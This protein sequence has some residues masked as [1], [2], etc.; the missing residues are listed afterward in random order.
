MAGRCLILSLT[1]AAWLLGA[2]SVLGATRYDPRLRFRTVSTPR[3]DIHFHQ[4]GERMAGRLA[5]FIEAAAAEVDASIGPAVGRV[6]VILVDQHDLSNGWATPLPYNT[7]EISAAAPPAESVIGNTDDWLRLVFIHEYTHIAHLSRAGGWIGALRR[8]FGRMPVL[9]P[10]LYQPIWG[11]EGLATWQ[12]S[13]STAQGRVNAGDFRLLLKRAAGTGRF[14]PLDRAN[15]GN[16]DWPGGTTPYLYGAYFHAFLAER[17]GAESLR[18]LADETARRL[19]YFAP[20]AYRKVYGQSVGS[21]WRE[22]QEATRED[23]EAD[24]DAERLTFHGFNVTGPRVGADGRIFYSVSNPHTFPALMELRHPGGTPREVT[25]RYQGRAIALAGRH[26]VVDEID[27]VRSVGLQSDLYLIDPEDGERRRLTREARAL[28]P[29]VAPGG[30]TVA[31]VV[32]LHDRR[33]I[34]T[35]ALPAAGE[36]TPDILIGEE[37][38]DYSLPRWSPDGRWIAAERRRL[39][40]PSEIVV[41]DP[42]GRTVRVLASLPGG[43]SASPVWTPDGTHVLF[44]A[45][46]N[47][48]PFQ[49][50]RAHVATGVIERLEGTGRSARSPDVSPD[51]S[52]LVYVGYTAEGYDL[53]SLSMADARWTGVGAAGRSESPGSTFTGGVAADRAEPR[54]YSA[55]KTLAP[56]FWTPTVESDGDELVI[57]GA[58]GSADALGRHAYGVEGGWS[59][60][61]RPDWRVAYAYDRWRP[62]VFAALSDDTDPWRDGVVRTREADLGMLLRVSRVRFTHATFA[63]L[64][65]AADEFAC[66]GCAPPVDAQLRRSALRLGWNFSNAR[67]FGYSIS[68]EEGGRVS[69]TLELPRTALGSDGNGAAATLDGRRYWRLWPRHGVLA[70]RGA[71]AAS[72]GDENSLREFRASG[73]GPQTAGFGFGRGAVGL[74]RGFSEEAVTGTRAAVVNLDYRVPL[75]RVDRGFGTIPIF[76]RSLHGAVFLDAGH[77]WTDVARWQDRKLSVGAEISTDT[78]V[79]FALPVTFTAGAAWRHGAAGDERS[80]AAFVRVGRAF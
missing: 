78:V 44:A 36:A 39:N 72:W 6:Q 58:T 60:R 24:V 56:R 19:P 55:W 8:P 70:L 50:H 65:T 21:L 23:R 13:A 43:R 63:S 66:A 61:A 29:D 27:L 34:A 15:G 25:P 7:I 69:S 47:D 48:G 4:G 35:F 76:V 57:G 33:A 12:E 22:F 64:H 32:Q 31:C 80:M 16:V 1:A 14:E 28:D 52:L 42:G 2:A 53:F 11:I 10:N 75:A 26:L 49:I 30:S 62:T 79:G 41:V 45:A 68:P 77:A 20:R 17:H 71:A 46:V 67:A 37:G 5:R 73:H 40:G 59:S 51:G 18:R 74:L 3:F 9:F 38:T 54:P